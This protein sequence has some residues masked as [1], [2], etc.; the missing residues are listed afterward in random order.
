VISNLNAK[1]QLFLADVERIQNAASGASRRLSS[2]LRITE[3]SD[4]PDQISPLLQLRAQRAHIA[5][6]QTNLSL[7]QANAQAADS[8][9][10]SAIQLMDSAQSL[11]TEAAS[12][13]TTASG[14]ATIANQIEAIQQRMLAIANTSVQG[15]Y[16]FSGDDDRTPAYA[17]DTQGT[18][19]ETG[20][21]R[22]SSAAATRHV[23]EPTG[24][25][26]AS[27]MNA[28]SIFDARDGNGAVTQ[29]NVF[30]SL[31]RLRTE[32]LDPNTTA[33]SIRDTIGDLQQASEQLNIAQA[34]Y[35]DVQ[36]RIQSAQDAAASRKTQIETRISG[37]ADA[38]AAGDA[39]ALA[40]ANTQLTA[41]FQ[42]QAQIPRKTLFDYLS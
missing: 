38:D 11:A 24:G 8:A 36:N 28:Q 33:D 3:A 21:A 17:V 5:Q 12:D 26:F 23:E 15:S 39:L 14:R 40:Q 37:I 4:S 9:L 29:S 30:Y 35:G 20:M 6:V 34:F 13:L 18:S 41:A 2:G 22:V 31:Q 25:S 42:A 16:I 7:A 19:P 10:S 27:S 1:S 32:L